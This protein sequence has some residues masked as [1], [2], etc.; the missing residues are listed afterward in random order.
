MKISKADQDLIY[1]DWWLRHQGNNAHTNPVHQQK[2]KPNDYL[3]FLMKCRDHAERCGDNDIACKIVYELAGWENANEVPWDKPLEL[4]LTVGQ[5]YISPA[6]LTVLQDGSIV[7][8]GRGMSGTYEG[9]TINA[10]CGP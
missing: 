3:L 1:F 4:E 5:D 9:L 8:L 6:A 10:D 2:F 7:H